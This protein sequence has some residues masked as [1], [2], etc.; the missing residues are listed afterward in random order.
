MFVFLKLVLAE[1]A[2][3]SLAKRDGITGVVTNLDSRIV[4]TSFGGGE[5]I[6]TVT[7]TVPVTLSRNDEIIAIA[8]RDTGTFSALAGSQIEV[9]IY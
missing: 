4:S 5:G 7:L 3:F 1:K 6:A 2:S 9:I 8:R